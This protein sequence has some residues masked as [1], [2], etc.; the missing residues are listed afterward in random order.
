[1]RSAVRMRLGLVAAREI[2]TQ[3]QSEKVVD[4]MP[5]IAENVCAA[6][7]MKLARV[8]HESNEVALALLQG[9][10][11]QPNRFE[12]RD[13]YVG[14]AVQDE[15]RALQAM[16]GENGRSLRVDFRF[17]LRGADAADGPVSMVGVVVIHD[18]VDDACDV[19]ASAEE[20]GL[21]GH[22]DE[23]EKTA[24]AQAPDA[25]TVGINIGQGL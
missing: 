13:V 22:G 8:H 14:R 7:V 4:P 12:V 15:Q 1:M 24:V 21:I 6:K 18:V 23:C 25:D 3:V 2:S 11:N 10:V 17:L 9:L 16:D 20:R 19:D 5:G